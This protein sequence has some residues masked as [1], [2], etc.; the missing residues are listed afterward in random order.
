MTR[1]QRVHVGSR[2]TASTCHSLNDSKAV[3]STAK[4]AK[5]TTSVKENQSTNPRAAARVRHSRRS[6]RKSSTGSLS[7]ANAGGGGDAN[8]RLNMTAP[9]RYSKSSRSTSSANAAPDK[10][11]TVFKYEAF[12]S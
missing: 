3:V 1:F 11:E 2:E 7:D 10:T 9:P 4:L 6:P 12:S 5:A 8:N